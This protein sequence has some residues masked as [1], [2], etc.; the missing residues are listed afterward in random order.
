MPDPKEGR[1][2][3][4]RARSEEHEGRSK[5]QDDAPPLPPAD[6]AQRKIDVQ[7]NKVVTQSPPSEADLERRDARA[8]GAMPYGRGGSRRGK[9]ADGGPTAEDRPKS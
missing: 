1:R 4:P 8:H 9:P 7:N 5:N 3:D 6:E 2:T